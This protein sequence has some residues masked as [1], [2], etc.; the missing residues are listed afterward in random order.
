MNTPTTNNFGDFTYDNMNEFETGDH[1]FFPG[2]Y[3]PTFINYTEGI[4]VATGADATLWCGF[5]ME[6]IR[7]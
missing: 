6:L 5:Y 7:I 4:Y 3:F 1:P 2:R